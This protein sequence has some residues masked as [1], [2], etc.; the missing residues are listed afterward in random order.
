MI[1]SLDLFAGAGGLTAGLHAAGPF[2]TVAAVEMDPQAAA[3]FAA[4]F[5]DVV[6]CA[7]IGDWLGGE[8]PEV[9]VVVG[10]PPCQGFSLLGRRDET[11]PRNALW[12]SYGEAVRRASPEIF[13]MENVAAFATSKELPALL[14]EVR[15]GG[16]F[17]GFELEARVLDASRHG[18]A[19]RRRRTIIIGRRPGLAFRWP[20]PQPERTLRDAIG[21]LPPVP[22]CPKGLPR[23]ISPR[24]LHFAR[25][26]SDLSLARIRS[27]PPGGSRFDI[28]DHLLPDCWRRHT[29]GS[30]DVMG[31]LRWDR[32]SVTI[33][34]EFMKPE[35]GRYLHPDE[36]RALTH[37]EAAAIQGFPDSHRFV[38]SDTA[39]ARQI[40]NAVPVPLA[41]ALGRSIAEA[42]GAQ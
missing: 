8:V 17:E 3:S 35:K 33:R 5:G 2:E 37:A 14:D 20:E 42:L 21:H 25:A 30:R 36:H 13:V 10:G 1:R 41:E 7:P 18:A 23:P 24:D 15:P 12:R 39:I 40:G 19:Q 4:T 32:P 27:I 38:G 29:T 28:P 11:D 6:A 26:Y 31:R 9:D 34:T 16:M 22:D